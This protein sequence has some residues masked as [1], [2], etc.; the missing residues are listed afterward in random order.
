MIRYLILMYISFLFLSCT[1]SI[2]LVQISDFAPTYKPLSQGSIVQSRSE[3]NV[4]LGFTTETNYVDEAYNK[5]QN[6]CTN[7]SIQAIS[8]QYVTSHGFFSWT[9]AIEMQGLCIK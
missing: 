8:T 3:Q 2:H 9:N 7:G 5:L 1:H 6:T 4:F